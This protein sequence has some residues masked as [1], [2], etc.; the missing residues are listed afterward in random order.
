MMVADEASL[1]FASQSG[2]YRISFILATILRSPLH[3]VPQ[4]LVK[5]SMPVSA[6]VRAARVVAL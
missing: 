5:F 2:P 3:L 6:R 4:P 1:Q